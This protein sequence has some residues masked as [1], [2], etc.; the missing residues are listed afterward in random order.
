[1]EKCKW[2][3]ISKYESVLK[4]ETGWIYETWNPDYETD[5]SI[6]ISDRQHLNEPDFQKAEENYRLGG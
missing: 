1:M 5:N 2:Y 3:Q 6:Y 4:L